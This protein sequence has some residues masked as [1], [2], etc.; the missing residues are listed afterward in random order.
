MSG[1]GNITRRGPDTWRLRWEAEGSTDA[2]RITLSETVRGTKRDAQE[3]LTQL[4][5]ERDAGMST[6]PRKL[7]VAQHVRSW[8]DSDRNLS[9][10]TRERYCQLA[11]QQIIP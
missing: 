10:K 9:P 3:R 1:R 11:E 8:L 2:K 5:T 4:L 6:A 7:T